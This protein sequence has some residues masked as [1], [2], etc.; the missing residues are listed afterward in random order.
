MTGAAA[1]DGG[2][3]TEGTV[4]GAPAPDGGGSTD[5]APREAGAGEQAATRGEVAPLAGRRVLVARAAGQADVLAD[6]LRACGA[7]PV[8]APVLAIEPGDAAALRA[9]VRDVAAGRTTW[10]GFT[11]PNGVDAVAEALV[12]EHLDARVLDRLAP[13]V[14]AAAAGPSGIAAVGSG[15]AARLWERLRCL[16]DLIPPAATTQS[17]GEAF[18]SG[19]GRVLLPRAD[20]ANPALPTLIADRG[21]VVEEVVAYRTVRPEAL[22]AAV[23]TGLGDGSIDLVALGSPSTARNLVAL[24]DGAPLRAAAVSIG[25]VTSRACAELGIEVVAE[26]DPHDLDGLVAAVVAAGRR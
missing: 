15:T 4:A 2:G 26:A 10:I 3:P 6:R 9:A 13:P 7:D 24:L 5:G 18:P 11:S 17:L 8:L 19:A 23:V 21:Y 16:P 22:P 25:P 12:A 14:D 1:P 20:I